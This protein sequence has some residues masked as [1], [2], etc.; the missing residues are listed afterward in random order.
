MRIGFVYDIL[1]NV[2]PSATALTLTELT[3]ELFSSAQA[4]SLVSGLRH[5]GHAV[6]VIDGAAAFTKDVLRYRDELDLVFNEA[7]GLFGPDRKM[8]IPA[9]CRIHGIPYLGSDAYAVTLARNKWHTLAVASYAGVVVPESRLVPM[10]SCNEADQW[11]SFPAIVKPNFESSSI[12]I[13]GSSIVTD[14]VSLRQQVASV[15]AIYR[16]AA[17][18]QVFVP[19]LE[20]QVSLIGNKPPQPLAVVSV[21]PPGDREVITN[22]D[23]RA[24]TVTISPYRDGMIKEKVVEDARHLFEALTLQDYGRM[25]FRVTSDAELFFI[26][27][28]THPHIT[29]DSAFAVSAELAGFSFTEMLS[30]LLSAAHQRYL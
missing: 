18:V 30:A 29:P 1:E 6:S 13:S 22:E 7:K 14:T 3:T 5:L 26:E 20:L 11:S 2:F 21:R 9:L 23:W 19:G 27:A 4:N 25:D 10:G 16:Q 24:N 15:H 28:S 8:I 17:L 12:G